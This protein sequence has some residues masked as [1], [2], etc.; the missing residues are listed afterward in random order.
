MTERR[1]S[2]SVNY[3]ETNLIEVDAVEP[4]VQSCVDTIDV[5]QVNTSSHLEPRCAARV[6]L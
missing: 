2:D 6:Y 4:T 5:L 1:A 3:R